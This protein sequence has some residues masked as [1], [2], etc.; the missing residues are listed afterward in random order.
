LVIPA[1]VAM[2]AMGAMVDMNVSGEEA[3]AISP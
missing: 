1:M 2:G 3:A